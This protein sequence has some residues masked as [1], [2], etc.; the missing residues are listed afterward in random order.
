MYLTLYLS[1]ILSLQGSS[2][3]GY[4]QLQTSDRFLMTKEQLMD[5]MCLALGG[6]ISGF[7]SLPFLLIL[8]FCRPACFFLPQPPL[9]TILIESIHF[10]EVSSGAQDDLEKVTQSAYN[11]GQEER[12]GEEKLE[13]WF[14]HPPPCHFSFFLFFSSFFPFFLSFFLSSYV[15]WFK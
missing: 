9:I 11:Q 3:L 2:A 13:Y 12:E 8:L 14:S 5:Q 15:V 4:A 10:G 6:R 1:L 7:F